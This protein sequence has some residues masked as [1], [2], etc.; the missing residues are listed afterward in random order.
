ME[1]IHSLLITV[2]PIYQCSIRISMIANW[3]QLLG[4]KPWGQ[5]KS[6]YVYCVGPSNNWKVGR[7]VNHEE[8]WSSRL[9]DAIIL[10]AVRLQI[11][12]GSSNH[13]IW[14][15]V[16]HCFLVKWHILH[17]VE[18]LEYDRYGK[19]KTT[20]YRFIRLN[21]VFDTQLVQH[22]FD[23]LRYGKTKKPPFRI[24]EN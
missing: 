13:R 23:R 14:W 11:D 8:M 18:N 6:G 9:G 1:S 10:N 12:S 5:D 24:L 3:L 7:K 20:I 19:V 4:R 21:D 17:L 16:E 15:F 22:V 2:T